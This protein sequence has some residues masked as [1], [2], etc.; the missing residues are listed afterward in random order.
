[1]V[2]GVEVHT[3]G[4]AHVLDA[5]DAGG[6]THVRVA[7]DD[8]LDL[9]PRIAPGS[10]TGVRI[11]FPDPWLKNRQRHRRLVREQVVPLLV[12]RLRVGGLL[13]VATDIDDYARQVLEVVAG[14]PRLAGGVVPRPEWRPLTRFE[15]RGLDAGRDPVD[16]I[17]TRVS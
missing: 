9:L 15:R 8:A 2:I 5:I 10:L 11:W 7:E 13:H 17:F 12:E 6:W 3:P 4:V 14:E 1:C 16:M